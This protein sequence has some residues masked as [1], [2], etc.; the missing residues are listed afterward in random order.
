M[1]GN[2]GWALASVVSLGI[3][4]LA[5]AADLPVYKKAPAPVVE[6]Y[7]WTGFYVG[8]EGAETLDGHK[9]FTAPMIRASDYPIFLKPMRS[10]PRPAWPV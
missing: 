8:L 5:S 6:S 1:R 9:S 10:T 7:N 4:G 3:S 2:F